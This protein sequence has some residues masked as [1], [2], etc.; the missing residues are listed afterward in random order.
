MISVGSDESVLVFLSRRSD[1]FRDAWIR[2]TIPF[3][4]SRSTWGRG[5]IAECRDD[6]NRF[7][8]W[9]QRSLC[10]RGCTPEGL[11]GGA[12][13]LAERGWFERLLWMAHYD[14]PEGRMAERGV[15]DVLW[16]VRASE[17]PWDCCGKDRQRASSSQ[18]P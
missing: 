6:P 13:W 8:G 3:W 18:F 9:D 16:A 11:P 17:G 7:S 4:W 15:E 5:G 12:M 2:C 1:S 14:S 10:V